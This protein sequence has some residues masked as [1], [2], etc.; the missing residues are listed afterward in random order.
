MTPSQVDEALEA[1]RRDLGLRIHREYRGVTEGVLK[2]RALEQAVRSN[3]QL[4]DST[5]KSVLAGVR[6]QLDVLNVEQQL[7]TTHR[8]LIQARY[9][10]LMSRLRL[11]SSV[12]SLGDD[13]IDQINDYL[14]PELLVTN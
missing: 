9:F 8:D 7:A 5:R 11:A 1:M 4:L 13:D 14:G 12:G 3:E 2:I 10:Y 6:T